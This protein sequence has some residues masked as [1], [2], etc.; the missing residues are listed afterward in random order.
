MTGNVHCQGDVDADFLRN[1]LQGLIDVVTGVAV[2]VALVGR[3]AL[4]YREQ[5][6]RGIFRV[7][8]DDC[9][10]PNFDNFSDIIKPFT[11]K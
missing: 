2:L 6:L 7:F 3:G 10:A 11:I 8:V 9:R 5:V 4:D 1:L